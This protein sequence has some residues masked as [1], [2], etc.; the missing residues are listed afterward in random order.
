MKK[1]CQAILEKYFYKNI[2]T[3][4]DKPIGQNHA[5]SF[6]GSLLIVIKKPHT[7]NM[8]AAF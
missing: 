2:M 7:S 1:N 5:I 6:Y 8:Y 4:K 3:A